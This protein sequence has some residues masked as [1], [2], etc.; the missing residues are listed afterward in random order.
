MTKIR[1]EDIDM[2][3]NIKHRLYNYIKAT[4]QEYAIPRIVNKRIVVLNGNLIGLDSI[5]ARLSSEFPRGKM[6]VLK[7]ECN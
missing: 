5:L 4:G 7:E 1:C 2:A 6:E 3:Y